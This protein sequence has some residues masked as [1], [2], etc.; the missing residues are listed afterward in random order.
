MRIKE[1]LTPPTP[2]QGVVKSLQRR[3][4]RRIPWQDVEDPD[5]DTK[6]S[7][8]TTLNLGEALNNKEFTERDDTV[9]QPVTKILRKKTF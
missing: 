7:L 8:Y 9:S 3:V 2:L 1:V 6:A 5:L 4:T